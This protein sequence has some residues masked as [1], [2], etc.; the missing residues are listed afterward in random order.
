M[1]A[2]AAVESPDAGGAQAS[3]FEIV[4]QRSDAGSL[5][6][7]WGA[8]P[9][10]IHAV[11]DD[12]MIFDY[13]GTRWSQVVGTTGAKLGG[14][15][16]TGPKDIYAVGTLSADARGIILHY[17]GLG[18]TEETELPTGLVSVWGTDGV[19]YA[20]GL[21]GI[22]YK[23]TASRG[24]YKLIALEAN[25]Y[26]A[27]TRYAPIL[28]SIAGNA[29]DK[30]LIAG[31][32]DT[33]FLFRGSSQWVPLYDPVDR[34][35]A[36]RSVWGPKSATL[37]LYVGAN[38]FGVW[39]YTES[40]VTLKLH[41]EKDASEKASQSVW[42]IW[43]TTSDRVIFAGDSGRI[44]T[45]DGGSSGLRIWPS[46]TRRA[47]FGVWGSAPDNVWMVGDGATILRGRMP[48]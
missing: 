11:G 32:V 34:T 4:Q 2:D 39:Q 15:W 23:K 17:N 6:A 40:D 8:G 13:D 14:V 28:F 10:D 7:I 22:V 46:P 35:R 19:V 25:P 24:W 3:T 20:G 42:G 16:G 30:V 43:G 12:G 36:F 26:I 38:Y 27:K 9:N 21:D 33:V 45:Y 47:L 1:P 31:D 37:K 18:W 5:N 48:E 44:M 41:E 29:A